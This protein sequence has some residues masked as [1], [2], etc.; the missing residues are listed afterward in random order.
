MTNEKKETLFPIA[1]LKV[2]E[3]MNWTNPL[4]EEE[5]EVEEDVRVVDEDSG[6]TD[7][8]SSFAVVDVLLWNERVGVVEVSVL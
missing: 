5:D 2:E 8:T 6:V 3:E 1:A 4:A 7:V